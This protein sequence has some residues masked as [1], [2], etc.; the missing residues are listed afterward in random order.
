[1]LVIPTSVP[2]RHRWGVPEARRPVS[3]VQSASPRSQ[4]RGFVWKKVSGLGSNMKSW[5]L[6]SVHMYTCT[7]VDTPHPISAWTHIAHSI[8]MHTRM[9]AHVHTHRPNNVNVTWFLSFSMHYLS[10]PHCAGF[11]SFIVMLVTIGQSSSL[12]LPTLWVHQKWVGEVALIFKALLT[13]QARAIA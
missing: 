11:K 8:C 1:M 7:H 5:S 13:K 10:F 3:L 6:A 9:H 4:W 2:E 12:R